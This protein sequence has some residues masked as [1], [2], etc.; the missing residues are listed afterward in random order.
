MPL[1]PGLALVTGA[2]GFVGAAVARA[3]LDAGHEVR[4]LARRNS[5]RRN[6]AGLDV[7]VS[8]GSLEDGASLTA[9]VADCRYLFHVAADYRLWVPDPAAM[10][11]ANVDGTRIL[12]LAALGAGVERIVYT[13]SVATLGLVKDGIAD[14]TTPSA[15]AEMIGPYKRSKFL[16]EEAVKALIAERG[17]P[18][19]IVNPSTPIGPGDVKPTPTGRIIVE[20][21]R[22]KMPGYVDTGLNIVHVDDVAAGQL[23]AAERGKI[24]E[25]YILGGENLGLA[26]ILAIVAQVVG[27]RPPMLKIPY[28]V[29]LPIAAGAEMM[30]RITGREPFASL[31]GVRMSRKKMYFSSA[32]A[33]RELGYRARPAREAIADAI[34]WFEANGYLTKGN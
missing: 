4:V 12:M 19:V 15:E 8:E 30:A 23:L 16:A 6:L 11:R 10:F 33:M 22:G 1:A 13:S 25:R 3:L 26:E 17:L 21:A 32:K 2:T 34:A 24:G 20:A 18:A 29:V 9:A 7:A 5:D 27:R 14:E 31:D 28:A